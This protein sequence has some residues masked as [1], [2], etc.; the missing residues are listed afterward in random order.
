ML[1]GSELFNGLMITFLK[2]T[3]AVTVKTDEVKSPKQ[4]VAFQKYRKTF[5]R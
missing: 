3:R 5:A 1:N 2:G 4:R